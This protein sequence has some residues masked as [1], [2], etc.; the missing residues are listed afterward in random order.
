MTKYALVLIRWLQSLQ[1]QPMRSRLLCWT[2]LSQSVH[3]DRKFPARN[4]GLF[5]CDNCKVN[6][7]FTLTTAFEHTVLSRWMLPPPPCADLE[8]PQAAQNNHIYSKYSTSLQQ[9]VS[10][11]MYWLC[12]A[13]HLSPGKEI[14]IFRDAPVP[15]RR[16][17]H[18]SAD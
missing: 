1:V 6:I 3:E 13:G 15:T 11:Y 10:Y 17:A 16:P 4:P 2:L 18:R 5:D 12:T 9:L 7:F 14:T 8:I